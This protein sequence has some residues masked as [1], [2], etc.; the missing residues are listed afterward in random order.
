MLYCR[1]AKLAEDDAEPAQHCCTDLCTYSA[2]AAPPR[3]TRTCARVPWGGGVCTVCAKVC[4]AV[5]SWFCIVFGQSCC[6]TLP[7]LAH[8]LGPANSVLHSNRADASWSECV[9]MIL[10]AHSCLSML[11]VSH[12]VVCCP[13]S[14]GKTWHPLEQ[15]RVCVLP[16]KWL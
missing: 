15:A 4:A 9:S 6:P 14:T 13:C 2:H 8:I 16:A 3:H 10:D 12:L 5:L 11:A 7:S 1:S